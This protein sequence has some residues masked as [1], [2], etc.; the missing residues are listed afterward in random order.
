MP[1]PE[2]P[3]A[4]APAR[5]RAAAAL[6]LG[7]AVTRLAGAEPAFQR[8]FEFVLAKGTAPPGF[9]L[10][11]RSKE[12]V[13][14]RPEDLSAAAA[15]AAES[16]SVSPPPKRR[17]FWI[18]VVTVAALA[19]SA[20]NSFTDHP[21]GTFRFHNEQW[22]GRH[23]YAGGADKVSHFNSYN[24]VARLMSEVYGDLGVPAD[25]APL[26]GSAVSALAGL[27]TEI[28]DGTNRYGFSYEDLISDTAGAAT[29]FVTARYGLDD[30]LGFRTGVIPHP[31]VIGQPNG[32]FG[33][34]YTEE[35]Y[36]ADMKISGLAQ[37]LHFRPGLARFLLLSTTYGAKGYPY[38]VP[39]VR[40][41]QV[42]LEVGLHVTEILRAAGLRND[43]WWQ[44]VLF[45]ILD[46]VR[47]PY[48]SVG[49]QYDLNHKKWRGPGI[50]DRF[51]G[52]GH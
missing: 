37:R 45:V 17:P 31:Q 48:T 30:L 20:L 12:Q 21:S 10:G 9:R 7:L 22:F 50:G 46:S 39:G 25:R 28:G 13:V 34:D 16:E 6:V 52:G 14:I 29:A 38:A 27:V 4:C 35:I 49:V 33:K 5:R 42:G 24:T 26:Y 19:G 40:E 43:H 47:I 32:G 51:P 44:R 3:P 1:T 8:S 18:G 11:L 36:T 15:A 41:R 2:S 23:T